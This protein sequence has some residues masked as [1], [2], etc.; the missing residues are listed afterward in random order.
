VNFKVVI[1]DG[2]GESTDVEGTVLAEVGAE[3]IRAPKG[4]PDEARALVADADAILCDA[5][6]ITADLLD[7]APKLRVVSEY[8]IGYDNID[9]PAASARGIW[10]ANVPGFCADEVAN[11]TMALILAANRR[12]IALDRSVRDS[13]W[14]A[15]GVAGGVERLSGQVLGL[16]GFGQIG[17]RVARRAVAFGLRVL[18]NSPRTTPDLAREHGAERVDLDD[19]FTRSDY[20]SLH[21]PANPSTRGL[22]DATALA[23]LKPTAWLINTARGSIVDEEALIAA[24]RSGRISGAALDV[25]RVEPPP[26]D[27]PFRDLPNVILTPHAAFYSR[28]SL[29]ELRRRATGNVAAVLAGGIPNEPVNP[30]IVPWFAAPNR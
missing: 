29:I 26:P 7:G 14:D 12:L 28:Q 24:L 11:H 21:L 2:P 1:L 3:V 18:V 19:L 20:V 10:V 25:R 13:H 27:D 30:G 8:G 6:P 16:V 9:V 4:T 15:I 5:T 23:R 17:R 22:I